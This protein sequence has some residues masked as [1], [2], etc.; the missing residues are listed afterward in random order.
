MR[1]AAPRGARAAGRRDRGPCLCDHGCGL[2]QPGQRPG[3]RPAG[4]PPASGVAACASPGPPPQVGR[5]RPCANTGPPR[6]ACPSSAGHT[7]P[8]WRVQ[9]RSML[10][11]RPMPTP[12]AP[13]HGS[14]QRGPIGRGHLGGAA[15]AWRSLQAFYTLRHIA[16]QP[17][18]H[19]GLALAN[20]R[21]PLG[22]LQ[23]VRPREQD[24]LRP[25][26]Q[27]GSFRGAIEVIEFLAWQWWQRWYLAWSHTTRIPAFINTFM[28]VLR[29]ITPSSTLCVAYL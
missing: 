9:K 11:L 17:A 24:H 27:P 16:L 10:R 28:V 22:H 21:R 6:T 13:A 1:P 4:R 7:T 2:S 8:P 5:P 23:P 29:I 14:E 26:P 20:D 12:G 18:Q 25:R 19:R 3:G 15:R